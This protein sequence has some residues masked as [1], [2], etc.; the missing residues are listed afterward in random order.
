MQDS[1][2]FKHD[3][4]L[5]LG[6]PQHP[7][8]TR[9][10]FYVLIIPSSQPLPSRNRNSLT[11]TT[12]LSNQWPSGLFVEFLGIQLSSQTF[13]L[14]P[15]LILH[16]KPSQDASPCIRHPLRAFRRK[17]IVILEV[18]HM[19][20]LEKSKSGCVTTL[21]ACLAKSNSNSIANC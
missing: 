21:H 5:S 12:S 3:L 10:F 7:H 14:W 20:T 8:Q 15:S 4:W 19:E 9:F 6:C 18:P 13:T 1:Q 11:L 17:E 16:T 2:R